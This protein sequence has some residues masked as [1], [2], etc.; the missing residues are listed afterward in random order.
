WIEG[1]PPCVVL[2]ARDRPPHARLELA[3]EEDVTNHARRPGS[4]LVREELRSGHEDPVPAPVA[5]PQEL[6]PTAHGEERRAAFYGVANRF[7]L[8]GEVGSDERLLAI[9]AAPDV[10]QV[11]CAGDKGIAEAHRV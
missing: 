8:A 6:V 5:P 10:E 9:L 1:R 4:R 11:V 3:L 7:A 2:E